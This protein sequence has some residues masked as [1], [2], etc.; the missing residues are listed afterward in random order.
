MYPWY[1][2]AM[3]R[4]GRELRQEL[5]EQ[6]KAHKWKDLKNDGVD[7]FKKCGK[8]SNENAWKWAMKLVTVNKDKFEDICQRYIDGNFDGW[9]GKGMCQAIKDSLSEIITNHK[10]ENNVTNQNM[11][12]YECSYPSLK[13]K[14]GKIY[15]NSVWSS[16]R[17]VAKRDTNKKSNAD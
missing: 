12:D 14:Y 4:K 1:I 3:Y 2:V 6:G 10:D 8:K 15:G 5:S 11:T 13:Q 9:L 16:M 17:Y 7:L